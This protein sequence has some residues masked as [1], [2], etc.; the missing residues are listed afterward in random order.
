MI[1]TQKNIGNNSSGLVG[2]IF[3]FSHTPSF[4]ISLMLSFRVELLT[5]QHHQTKPNPN[6]LS[7]H[8]E[9][10]RERLLLRDETMCCN[11][12]DKLNLFIPSSEA[13][14]NFRQSEFSITLD[15]DDE[16]SL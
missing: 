3:H 4:A 16:E 8:L 13:H 6:L 10:E 15:D 5:S 12:N 1:T 9:K 14:L 11:L 2:G 7:E